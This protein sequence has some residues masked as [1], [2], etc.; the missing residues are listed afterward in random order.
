[1]DPLE[2][3]KLERELEFLKESFESNVISE[4]E[5]DSARERIRSWMKQD[6]QKPKK[7]E[8]AGK[9]EPKKKEKAKPQKEAKKEPSPEK[10]AKKDDFSDL[11]IAEEPE[12]GAEP[13]EKAEEDI[14]GELLKRIE[15]EKV[16]VEEAAKRAEEED[17][18]SEEIEFETYEDSEEP[19]DEE[20]SLKP[21]STFS[22]GDEHL[23]ELEG[24]AIQDSSGE[25]PAGQKEES[26]FSSLLLLI[27]VVGAV[28]LI[29]FFFFKASLPDAGLGTEI[30]LPIVIA[31]S[32]DK[33]CVQEGM[34]GECTNPGTEKAKCEYTEAVSTQLTVLNTESCFNCGTA[35]TL[36]FLKELYPGLKPNEIDAG[37]EE[38]MALVKNLG[39]NMLP[40]YIFDSNLSGTENF[41]KT[42]QI[43]TEKGGNYILNDRSSGAN[44]YIERQEIKGRVDLFIEQGHESSNKAAESLE[45]FRNGFPNAMAFQHGK[46][47]ALTRQLGI[48]T[49]PA[50]LINNKVK[51][52]GYRLPSALETDYCAMNA[53]DRC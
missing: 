38:G 46:N 18:K 40:A 10:P 41:A 39:I 33:E 42:S 6:G 47:G 37:S 8:T 26:Q 24:Y 32:S 45:E 19:K 35:S 36:R 2:K 17:K 3:E 21:Q 43:F 51:V 34:V 52:L 4:E 13:T 7:A 20:P 15:E 1:M 27:I 44:F 23:K 48:N 31:C 53:D 11:L 30:P 16:S 28:F 14:D 50:F 5:Y 9:E 25:T 29:A 22:E 49:F 12:K